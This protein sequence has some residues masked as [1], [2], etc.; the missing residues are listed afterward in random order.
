LKHDITDALI[1][2]S[3]IIRKN[4]SFGWEDSEVFQ[5]QDVQELYRVLFDAL[6]DSFKGTEV[7]NI[8]DQVRVSVTINISSELEFRIFAKP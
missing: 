3:Y 1:I 2:Y 6:E 8:I 5:Q 7:E 4:R